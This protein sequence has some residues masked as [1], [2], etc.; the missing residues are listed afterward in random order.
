MV[1]QAR[2]YRLKQVQTYKPFMEWANFI[3][4]GGLHK[5]KTKR[6]APIYNVGRPFCQLETSTNEKVY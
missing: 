4:N 1:Q 5:N 3:E 2:N 6:A